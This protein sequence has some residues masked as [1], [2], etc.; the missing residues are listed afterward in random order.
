MIID[1]DRL[2]ELLNYQDARVRN[3]SVHALEKYFFDSHG[4]IEYLLQSIKLYPADC[5]SLVAGIK[6]FTPTKN[7]VREIVSII[8]ATDKHQNENST[9][10][11]F[12]LTRSLS[13]FPFD[14]L[15]G[16]RNIFLFTKEL[17]NIYEIAQNREEFKQQDPNYLWNELVELCNRCQ[18]KRIEG[19]DFQYGQLLI[20][21]LSKHRDKIKGKIIMLLSQEKPD[22]YHLNEYMVGLAGRLKLKPTV[23]FLF[24][25]LRESEF[26][27]T[28]HSLC[29]RAL[30]NIGTQEVVEGIAN[31]YSSNQKLRTAFADILKYI[32]YDYSE[33]LALLLIKKEQEVSVKTFLACALCDI[34]S[35]KGA[36]IIKDMIK[37]RRYDSKIATLVD[38]LIPVYVYHKE[39]F[40]DL[41]S[42]EANAKSYEIEQQENDPLFQMG[43]HLKEYLDFQKPIE[44]ETQESKFSSNKKVE[45]VISLKQARNKRKRERKKKK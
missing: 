13:A 35:L 39:S 10:I 5:L 34:F 14:A 32:P 29:I 38:D 20:E 43:Q 37:T 26:I 27:H 23:P 41:M 11:Y 45:N 1:K 24:R 31:L 22:N 15:A 28:V 16:N 42:L 25:I 6:F 12:H 7:D 18:K 30:G 21:G 33:D 4:I 9:N 40:D 17:S 2:T 36:D 3:A 44:K 8:N 19:E